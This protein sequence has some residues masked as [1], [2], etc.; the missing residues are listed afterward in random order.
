MRCKT[1]AALGLSLLITAATLTAQ[2]VKK[3]TPKPVKLGA[4]PVHLVLAQD[5]NEARFVV[6]EQLA[7]ATLPNDAIG[8]TSAI[9]GEIVLDA[10]G[11]V[12]STASRITIDLSTLTSDKDRRDRYIK[13]RT[14]VVDSFP[15]ATLVVTALQDLPATLPASGSFEFTLLGD[16]TIHGQTHPSS[17]QVSATADPMGYSG[18][19]TTHIHFADFGMTQPKVMVVLS[20]VDDIRLEYDFKLV[21]NP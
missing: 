18:T 7:G 4:A 15:T 17:W 20:V 12:D 1:V 3:T 14:I 16:L 10:R 2:T 11:K 13:G 5:G 6:R 9:S 8:R 19:A 21:R